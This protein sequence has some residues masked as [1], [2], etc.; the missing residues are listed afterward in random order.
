[1][2]K[3]VTI[4]LLSILLC[5]TSCKTNKNSSS[6]TSSSSSSKY[7]YRYE[8]YKFL[9]ELY[10]LDG[11]QKIIQKFK[12]EETFIMVFEGTTCHFCKSF[13][14][15]VL[16]PYLNSQKGR[17][18]SDD[19][20]YYYSSDFIGEIY[21]LI[22]NN[23]YDIAASYIDIYE[24]ELILPYYKPSYEEFEGSEYTT[25]VD[26]GDNFIFYAAETPSTIY[27]VNGQIMG[28]LYGDISSCENY[29][30]R[31]SETI[32]AWEKAKSNFEEGKEMFHEVIASL[33]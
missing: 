26:L 20:Y 6:S 33:Y 21:Q 23:S 5:S 30:L 29:L 14:E 31:F 17:E 19:I 1:M 3:I 28:F 11:T 9:M 4:A 24:K 16:F 2:K 32:D 10:G 27:V 12:N 18:Y 15:K 7:S 22:L 8:D 13:N 25:T